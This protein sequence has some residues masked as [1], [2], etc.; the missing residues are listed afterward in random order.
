MPGTD[1]TSS[2]D[3]GAPMNYWVSIFTGT[4]EE[5]RR[6]SKTEV[7]GDFAGGGGVID[8][9]WG[10][11]VDE[12]Y[13]SI[14]ST[15]TTRLELFVRE[16]GKERHFA[17]T[18]VDF[19]VRQGHRV[20]VLWAGRK[21]EKTGQYVILHNHTLEKSTRLKGF[22]TLIDPRIEMPQDVPTFTEEDLASEKRT[23]NFFIACAL[24]LGWIPGLL[25]VSNCTQ[26]CHQFS[27]G[28]LF[29]VPWLLTVLAA[30]TAWI[31]GWASAEEKMQKAKSAVERSRKEARERAEA[32][33]GRRTSAL[34]GQLR[35]AL[36]RVSSP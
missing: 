31:Y 34:E 17:F 7:D 2:G 33:R 29:T 11:T 1:V 6:G 24:L 25:V 13:G 5:C 22:T 21:G 10:G 4:V 26:A 18:D 32:E 30:V 12:V 14:V 23:W 35:A 3:N 8:P 28:A 20:S 16:G 27:D 36:A 9:R 19:P 15:T